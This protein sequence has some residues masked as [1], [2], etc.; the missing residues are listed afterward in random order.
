VPTGKGDAVVIVKTPLTVR[1]AVFT[2]RKAVP[3]EVVPAMETTYAVAVGTTSLAEILNVTT[4]VVPE[5]SVTLKALTMAVGG[6]LAA[7]FRVTSTLPGGIVPLGNPCPVTLIN[8]TPAS[9]ELGD[10]EAFSVTGVA[11]RSG[12][13]PESTASMN[14]GKQASLTADRKSFRAFIDDLPRS[15]VPLKC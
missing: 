4:S 12:N 9:P 3:V 10:A 8:D 11:A 1:A 13:D 15:N 6:P 5:T 2:L 7:G 14:T